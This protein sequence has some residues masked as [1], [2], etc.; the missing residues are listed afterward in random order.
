MTCL[1]PKN[2]LAS[3]KSS[4]VFFIGLFTTYYGERKN[5][6]MFRFGRVAMLPAD[7]IPWQDRPETPPELAELYLLETQTYGGN[8]GSPVFYMPEIIRRSEA[9]PTEEL[10]E[11]IRG[12][13]GEL[14]PIG[15]VNTPTANVPVTG[16]TSA[17]L[18]SPRLTFCMR[19]Y[20]RMR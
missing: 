13:Y 2:C 4:D 1:P 10:I 5:V 3:V 8:S 17:S 15:F 12:Y 18:P 19:Y 9:A 6:P 7:R 20:F 16:R 11:I 14:S